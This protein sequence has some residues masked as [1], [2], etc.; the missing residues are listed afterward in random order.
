MLALGLA[1]ELLAQEEPTQQPER[2]RPGLTRLADIPIPGEA[3]ASDVMELTVADAIR[4]GRMYNLDL[5]ADALVP[6]EQAAAI[7]IES[8]FFEPEFFGSVS[9][10]RATDPQRNVFQPSIKRESVSGE[11]G[12][13][14]RVVTGGSFEFSFSPTR[15]RQNT[16]TPGFPSRQFSSTMTATITQPLLRGG[17]STYAMRNVHSAQAEFA[18]A[19][20]R[21]ER[22]V[23][24]KI[25]DIVRAYWE[26]AYARQDYR[27]VFQALELAREQL[28]I[29]TERIRLRD[30]PARDRISDE[31]EVAR[32]LEELIRAENAIAQRED[33][34]K[35]LLFDGHDGAVWRRPIR[36]TSSFEGEF[37]AL[38]SDW[39]DLAIEARRTRPDVR[40]LRAD[41][42]IAEIAFE[43][44]EQDL[45]PQL[46]LVGSY[47]SR[48][49]QTS[50]PNAFGDTT[51][52]DF[53][54]WSLELQ[55]SVPV[56]NRA[57][58]STRDRASLALER[59]RRRLF[60][61]ELDVDDELRDALREL[62]T[63]SESVRAARESVRLAESVLDTARETLRVGRGTLFEV[64]QRNQELLDARQRLLRNQLDHHIA[65]ASLELAKGEFFG[66]P[67]DSK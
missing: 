17:W 30:L 4:I 40:A 38:E 31:A 26:L 39:R 59:A 42:R 41:V 19:R 15:L 23:Q 12:F 33:E 9:T 52:L 27:V 37:R 64:Q 47:A 7:S 46:D 56:G 50:F 55:L 66:Q 65:R 35:R 24:Q 61:A 8:A 2:E 34:L 11:L 54:D 51:D 6:L 10:G 18:G 22:Q 62:R 36:P 63:L 32:R 20:Y 44:A 45:L 3:D 25:V 1:P 58:R 16:N 49:V 53:P 48:G 13:R 5:R 67:D 28:R 29:T 60:A 57:A 14:Q 21:Y 43:V